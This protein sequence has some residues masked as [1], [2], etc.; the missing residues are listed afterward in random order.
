MS[1]SRISCRVSSFRPFE[2]L[3]LA[4]IAR[5]GLQF[6]EFKL[7]EPADR[8]AMLARLAS[9]GLTA[10][11]VQIPCP[12]ERPDVSEVVASALDGVA[13]FGAPL[14]LVCCQTHGL[15]L[16][17]VAARLRAAA[18]QARHRGLR[19]ALETHPDLAENA[20]VSLRTLDGVGHSSLGINFDPANIYFYNDGLDPVSELREIA[21]RVLAVHLKD[22]PGRRAE[23]NFPAL[24]QGVVD[25][26]AMF[27]VLDEAGFAGPYTIE[28]EGIEGETRDPS[29]VCS[30]VRES[31]EYLHRIGRLN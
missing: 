24:G 17:A 9:H 25:F 5:L 26:P 18:E 7:P 4:E 21:S 31:V 12:L 8:S 28:I 16:S 15:P 19:L 13:E 27:G 14:A 3:A 20:A 1:L 29:L 10:S 23:R 11:C 30:R 2:E 22:T 6:V